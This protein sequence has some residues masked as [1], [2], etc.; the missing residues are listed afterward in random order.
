MLARPLWSAQS[1]IGNIFLFGSSLF[2][3]LWKHFPAHLYAKSHCLLYTYIISLIWKL[4]QCKLSYK[5]RG[6]TLCI[7]RYVHLYC[8]D[9]KN[10]FVSLEWCS[11][12]RDKSIHPVQ[13][14]R[15]QKTWEERLLMTLYYNGISM[16]TFISSN[17]TY[18]DYM[19]LSDLILLSTLQNYKINVN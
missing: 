3:L 15:M 9:D 10:I 8:M 13:R 16:P 14:I 12:R 1:G 5:S 7:C 6:S 19:V 17:E 18:K 11:K 4:L 2:I